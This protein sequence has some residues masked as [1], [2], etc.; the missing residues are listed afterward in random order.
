MPAPLDRA[1]WSRPRPDGLGRR[2]DT[3]RGRLWMAGCLDRLD[4][5]PDRW[6]GDEPLTAQSRAEGPPGR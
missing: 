5:P 3:P 2:K 4:R 1:Y 6:G